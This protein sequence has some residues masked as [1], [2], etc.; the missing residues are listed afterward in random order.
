MSD[1]DWR[2]PIIDYLWIPIGVTDRKVKY[3]AL[4]YVI[5]GNKLLKKTPEEILLKYLGKN[6]AYLAISKIHRG[7]R[8]SYQADH[9]MKW[10][11]F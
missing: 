9:K 2:K 4:S 5:M 1:N 6:K 7:P 11:L 3:R 10:L 8:G